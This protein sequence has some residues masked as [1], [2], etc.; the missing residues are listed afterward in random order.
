MRKENVFFATAKILET[1]PVICPQHNSQ[2]Q[3]DKL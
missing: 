1:L 3:E 2:S